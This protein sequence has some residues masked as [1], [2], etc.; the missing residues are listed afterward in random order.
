[1]GAVDMGRVLSMDVNYMIENQYDF[2]I[3]VVILPSVLI[4]LL[5]VFLFMLLWIKIRSSYM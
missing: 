1:M 5:F 4:I 2:W 3:L